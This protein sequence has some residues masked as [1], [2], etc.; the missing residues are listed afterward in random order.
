MEQTYLG[1]TGL[2]VSELCLGTMTFGGAADE[3]TSRAIVERFRAAGGTFFDTADIYN[4]GASEQ[5]LGR[6][7][8]AERDQV[9]IAT[10]GHGVTGPGPNDRMS[11]RRH[12]ARAVDDSLRRLGTDWID[13]YQLHAWDP[14][15]PL[16]ETLSTLEDMVRAGKVLHVGVSNFTGWQIERAARI[17]E[18]R[19]WDPI[20]A[21]QP[22][23]SLVERLIEHETLPAAYANG[24]GILAWSP[25]AAGFLT[26]KYRREESREDIAGRGRFAQWVDNIDERGWAVLDAVRE[27]ADAHGVEPATVAVAWLLTRPRCVPIV[28]ATRPEQLDAS[29][30]AAA[31]E[32]TEQDVA[33]LDELSAPR[34]GYPWDFGTWPGRPAR[35]DWGAP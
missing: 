31:L 34:S 17:Q 15:T 30:A 9:V 12:L 26:G 13:L 27:I 21:L 2:V 14:T 22:Q 10:K 8:A 11:S 16:E 20:V 19:G 28:G 5:I 32:L 23:W 18:A 33:R 29:L 25:L 24:L 35:P 3:A 6:I 1:R 7:V 4:A